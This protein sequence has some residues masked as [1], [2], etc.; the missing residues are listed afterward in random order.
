MCQSTVFSSVSH[1]LL[2]DTKIYSIGHYYRALFLALIVDHSNCNHHQQ[3]QSAILSTAL[4]HL[5]IFPDISFKGS[6][7]AFLTSF[8]TLLT[9]L[10]RFSNTEY[11]LNLWF[12]VYDRLLLLDISALEPSSYCPT[13][14][15]PGFKHYDFHR[16]D[17]DCQ[18]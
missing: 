17:K 18:I 8:F 3:S 1:L 14:I 9:L 13:L 12:V 7:F 4:R 5:Y 15:Y 16:A 10:T 11:G 6:T 2:S